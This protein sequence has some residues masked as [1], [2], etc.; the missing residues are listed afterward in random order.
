MRCADWKAARSGMGFLPALH[1]M[2]MQ[3]A[4]KGDCSP[5]PGSPV[6]SLLSMMLISPGPGL[7]NLPDTTT[8]LALSCCVACKLL[9]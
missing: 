9:D 3:V 5:Q 6:D 2:Q 7:C 1:F 8:P 4:L